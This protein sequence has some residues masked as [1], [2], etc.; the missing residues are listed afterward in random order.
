MHGSKD[1]KISDFIAYPIRGGPVTADDRAIPM[2]V[3]SSPAEHV[4]LPVT[5]EG[6]PWT[7]H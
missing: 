7:V 6:R 5:P 4:F 1:E 3:L 2:D